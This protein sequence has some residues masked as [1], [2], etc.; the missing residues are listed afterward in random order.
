MPTWASAELGLKL[1][2]AWSLARIL[3]EGERPGRSRGAATS[4]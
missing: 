1:T 3:H 4:G 2:A